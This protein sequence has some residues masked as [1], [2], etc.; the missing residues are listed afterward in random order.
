MLIAFR[1]DAS[2]EIGTG[3][4]MRCLTLADGLVSA[5]AYVCFLSRHMPIYMQEFIASKGFEFNLLTTQNSDAQTDN[6]EHASWLGVS[7]QEDAISSID[8]MREMKVD[9]LIVDHYALDFKWESLLRK[10][11]RKLMVI[12]DLADRVHDCDMLLD[13]NYYSSMNSRY[14]KK[15]PPNCNLLLGP[16][17]TLLRH[18]FERAQA[19]IKPKGENVKRVLVF[20]GGIDAQNYTGQ[21]ILALNQLAHIQLD[22][23][24]V[25]G[26]QHPNRCQI[27]KDCDISGYSCHV[28][29]SN[30]SK[31]MADADLAIGA[32]GFACYEFASMKLPAILIPLTHIQATVAKELL[33]LNL[34][35][36]L[37]L[38][39]EDSVKKMRDEL[40]RLMDS[41]ILRKSISAACS[42][43]LDTNGVARVVNKIYEF[44]S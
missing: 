24:V 35:S 27:I 6:L 5:G 40:I 42:S 25:I 38:D 44:G 39:G 3:H 13:Q 41:T 31:L 28:Q 16:R 21:A 12:D 14:K 10:H 29:T 8:I 26:S 1:V 9:W 23:D 43:F 2:V 34:A 20:F 37:F 7:Q 33:K 36:V 17:Y 4:V 32:C 30:I 22:V 18:E 15:I 11:T 19:D